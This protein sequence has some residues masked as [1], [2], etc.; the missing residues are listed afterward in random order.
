MPRARRY[1]V[2]LVVL[3]TSLVVP[4][5]GRT[6]EPKTR[7]AAWATK[8]DRPGLPNL[9]KV[10]DRLYRGGQP[11]PEGIKELEKLGVKTIIGLRSAHSDKEIL[12]NAKIAYEAI[13]MQ[14]WDIKED[15]LVRFLQLATDK[16]RQPVFV[17]C[18]HGADRTGVLCAAYRVAV[19]GWTKQ[20]AIDE[21]TQG[22]F[23][24]H[25]FWT[26][27]VTFVNGLDVEKIKGKA[28]LK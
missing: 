27:L 3:L 25:A 11:E 17:H 8:L 16:N 28:G 9:H 24:F 13:P 10:N 12:G 18:Q 4:M 5:S 15:D 7:P 21:M 19:D 2:L 26:N 20:Q 22:G 14:A 1:W 6:A 23:G